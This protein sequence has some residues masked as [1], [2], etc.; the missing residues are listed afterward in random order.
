M[1]LRTIFESR[2][3]HASYSLLISGLCAALL[4]V[5]CDEVTPRQMTVT[6]A[7]RLRSIV[8]HF[9][10]DKHRLPRNVQELEDFDSLTKVV[11]YDGWRERFYMDFTVPTNI[12]FKSHGR[13]LSINSQNGANDMIW[14]FTAL[15]GYGKWIGTNNGC[16]S[17]HTYPTFSDGKRHI[18][19]TRPASPTFNR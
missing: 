19:A 15:D 10:A 7:W 4:I 3:G 14:S 18:K 12:F 8:N 5:S 9:V 17:W 2:P 11:E 6:N 13:K 16:Y 1:M